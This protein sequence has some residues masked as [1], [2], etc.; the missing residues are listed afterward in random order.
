MIRKA[1]N[2]VCSIW[3]F[4]VVCGVLLRSGVKRK[5]LAREIDCL[6]RPVEPVPSRGC[7]SC[8]CSR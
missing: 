1:F 5:D 8:G 2:V 6:L 3:A 7:G 4:I